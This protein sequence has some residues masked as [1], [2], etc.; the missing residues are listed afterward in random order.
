MLADFYE[1]CLALLAFLLQ[2]LF[3]PCA[4]L[5]TDRVFNL[6]ELVIS[7]VCVRSLVKDKE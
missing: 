5:G 6:V 3:I 2:K 7:I 4:G 1:K